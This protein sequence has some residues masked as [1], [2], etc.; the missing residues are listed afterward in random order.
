[1]T[2]RSGTLPLLAPRDLAAPIA[3]RAGQPVSGRAF[4]AAAARLA[5]RLPAQGRAINLC[6][7]RLHFA[8]G[9]AAALQR[10]QTS[11]MPP[12]ALPAPPPTP[13]PTPRPTSAPQ[14]TP[15]CHRS[16]APCRRSAC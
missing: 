5:E 11:L 6:Q 1:M 7:D 9:L 16:T 3:W 2:R 12:N 8:V 4:L 15:R 13:P 10:G 14:A